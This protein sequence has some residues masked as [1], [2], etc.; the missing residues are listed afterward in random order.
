MA[1]T[2]WTRGGVL[3]CLLGELEDAAGR[4]AGHRRDDVE[5]LIVNLGEGGGDLGKIR[6]FHL[7]LRASG[8]ADEGGVGFQY[9][10][11]EGQRGDHRP[12]AAGVRAG[13]PARLRSVG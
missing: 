9:E 2:P 1:P 12:N 13:R 4:G 11:L 3:C 10:R 8:C 6:G 7:P 5:R